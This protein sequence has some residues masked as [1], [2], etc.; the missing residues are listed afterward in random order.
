MVYQTF[1]YL[2]E[3]LTTSPWQKYYLS[4]LL[5]YLQTWASCFLN[6]QHL[7][8]LFPFPRTRQ[9]V[10]HLPSLFFGSWMLTCKGNETLNS[11]RGRDDDREWDQGKWHR[12]GESIKKKKKKRQPQWDAAR[13]KTYLVSDNWNVL[14]ES[15][16]W[17]CRDNQIHKQAYVKF[18]FLLVVPNGA[19]STAAPYC[20]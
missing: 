14:C 3:N 9:W 11:Q 1:H 2:H 4:P 7:L 13:V 5:I 12:S 8:Q 16:Q 19:G 20:F 17:K 6:L 18:Q 10:A 15:D